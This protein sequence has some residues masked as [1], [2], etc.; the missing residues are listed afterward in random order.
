MVVLHEELACKQGLWEMYCA[1]C[2]QHTMHAWLTALGVCWYMRS[3]VWV[4]CTGT[5]P[6]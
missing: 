4:L 1:L 2:M 5:I 3:V 6:A